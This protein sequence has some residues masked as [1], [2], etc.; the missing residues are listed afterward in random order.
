MMSNVDPYLLISK[1]V[2]CVVYVNDCL[3][4]SRSQSNIYNLMKSFKEDGPRYNWKHSKVCMSSWALISRR[5]IM[6]DFSFVK[7]D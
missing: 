4:W 5:W 2:I 7:L 3:F 6:V 1:T